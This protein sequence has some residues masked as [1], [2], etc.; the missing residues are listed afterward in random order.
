MAFAPQLADRLRCFVALPAKLFAA[1][2]YV[3]PL[4]VCRNKLIQGIIASP[5]GQPFP[6]E[7]QVFPYKIFIQH[8][9]ILLYQNKPS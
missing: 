2:Y 9:G 3:F 8:K 4:Y 1:K 7:I 6:D 5:G